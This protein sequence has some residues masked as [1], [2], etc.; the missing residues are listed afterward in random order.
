MAALLREKTDRCPM[1]IA[2][3]PEFAV[4]LRA[5]L[6]LGGKVSGNPHSAET[7]YDLEMAIGVDMLRG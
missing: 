1:Q 7:A 5:D 2:F 3:T 6:E 4:R